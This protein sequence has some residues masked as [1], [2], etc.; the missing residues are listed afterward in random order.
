MWVSGKP[1]QSQ[2][3]STKKRSRRGGTSLPAK[4]IEKDTDM[5]GLD[6]V[7]ENLINKHPVCLP[8]V[9]AGALLGFPTP[10]SCYVSKSRGEFPVRVVR[11]GSGLQVMTSDLLDY[12][13][14][15][16]SQAVPRAKK[17]APQPGAGRPR[18]ADSLAAA[19]C[20]LSV[21]E[22]RAQTKLAGV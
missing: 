12:I 6:A 9:A 14:T 17:A 15:G 18:K 3:P 8:F 2:K 21:A 5:N 4:R 22:W 13:R 19:K 1:S 11:T 10:G 20:G 7:A 16:V